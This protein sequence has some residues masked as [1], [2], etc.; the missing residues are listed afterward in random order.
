VLLQEKTRIRPP[1][2][3]APSRIAIAQIGRAARRPMSVVASDVGPWAPT[4]ASYRD[5]FATG[6]DRTL[7]GSRGG[8]AHLV[9]SGNLG[10]GTWTV[11]YDRYTS[12]GTTFLSGTESATGSP[13]TTLRLKAAITVTGQHTGSLKAD[14]TFDNTSTP[15]PTNHGTYTA[16][17]DGRRAPNPPAVGPCYSR[18]PHISPLKLRVR[19]TATSDLV[20]V[21]ADIHG[22]VRPVQ[23]ASITAGRQHRTTNAAGQAA[24][25]RTRKHAAPITAT[26]GFTFRAA[27][28]AG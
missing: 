2:P 28:A 18:L 22:D 25:P 15:V 23:G 11:T 8:T 19:R 1:G 9:V 17:Y 4:P 14:F 24:L 20:T 16:I 5:P 7:A 21:T 10:D 26:A 3:D 13:T 6:V 27:H 12:D